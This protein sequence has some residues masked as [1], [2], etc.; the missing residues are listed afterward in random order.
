MTS[1]ESEPPNLQVRNTFL[2]YVFPSADK[3]LKRSS[4]DSCLAGCFKD[5][6]FAGLIGKRTKQ[7]EA[8]PTDPIYTEDPADANT[9]GASFYPTLTP[10]DAEGSA[11][12]ASKHP[13]SSQPLPQANQSAPEQPPKRKPGLETTFDE[14]T[15]QEMAIWTV[16]AK[17]LKTNEK[18]IVSDQFNV[19]VGGQSLPFKMLIQP[20]PNFT[21]QR[22][23]GGSFKATEGKSKIEVICKGDI[24]NARYD[25]A[26]MNYC[27]CVG[28]SNEKPENWSVTVSN[29][30]LY[31]A[32][33]GLPKNADVWDLTLAVDDTGTFTVFL[34]ISP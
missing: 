16:E 3:T 17:V 23:H 22:K 29:D 7:R 4:S 5:T 28:K 30:F 33:S 15:S 19:Q 18:Q 1:E 25:T 26:V 31:N 14:S 2:T 20:H 9:F 6:C 10:Y 24:S 27:L 32:N 8:T 11:D 21:H 34:K 13:V 12:K